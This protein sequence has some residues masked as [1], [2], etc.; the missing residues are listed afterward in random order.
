MA[1]GIDSNSVLLGDHIQL[2]GA[3]EGPACIQ[4]ESPCSHTR[5]FSLTLKSGVTCV[6]RARGFEAMVHR[7]RVQR[8]LCDNV[9]DK[10]EI[11]I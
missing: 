10:G 1:R 5:Y 11:P 2:A 6:D 9:M 7:W 3:H 8:T 4:A